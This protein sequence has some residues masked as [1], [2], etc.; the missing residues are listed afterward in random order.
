MLWKA[1]CW[2]KQDQREIQ[3]TPLG[4]NCFPPKIIVSSLKFVAIF[5]HISCVAV[6]KNCAWRHATALCNTVL[7]G[8]GRGCGCAGGVAAAVAWV[9]KRE[10]SGR[11]NL[12]CSGIPKR[13]CSDP[14]NWSN[15]KKAGMYI[16]KVGMCYIAWYIPP[17]L[18][19]T[20][21]L[22]Y[23][24][25]RYNTLCYI[26]CYISKAIYPNGHVIYLC[27]ITCYIVKVVYTML[28][29]TNI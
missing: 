23:S 7:R 9:K 20:C 17:W 12:E 21:P 19:S 2:C 11:K 16:C 28:Y 10:C 22:L 14:G 18:Y 6:L 25:R 4:D 15:L 26:T 5:W 27:Y 8:R 3:A 13:E 24:K 29:I 1:G